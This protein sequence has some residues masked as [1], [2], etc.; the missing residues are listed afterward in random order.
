MANTDIY[1]DSPNGYHG[2]WAEDLYSV[3]SNYG[4]AQDLKDLVNAA[5]G[6]VR[7]LHLQ[8]NLRFLHNPEC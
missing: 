6:K 4:S 7:L 5:H 2:Y 3:N 1:V 8:P